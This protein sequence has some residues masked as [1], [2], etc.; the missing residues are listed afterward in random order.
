MEHNKLLLRLS[1]KLVTD[2]SCHTFFY[3]PSSKR[4]DRLAPSWNFSAP[5]FRVKALFSAEK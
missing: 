5:E 3:G 2:P 1:S 4:P